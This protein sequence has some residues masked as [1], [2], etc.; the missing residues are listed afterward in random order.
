MHESGITCEAAVI[1][2]STPRV[3][4][5]RGMK[6]AGGARFVSPALQRGEIALPEVRE[7]RK[8]GAFSIFLFS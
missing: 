8:D 7:S 3:S 5:P 1:C 2:E 6:R 4:D